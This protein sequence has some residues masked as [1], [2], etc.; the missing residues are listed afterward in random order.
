M[1]VLARYG[2]IRSSPRTIA[3]SFRSMANQ[4]QKLIRPQSE[5]VMVGQR[6]TMHLYSL[7]KVPIRK[8]DQT[9]T[10]HSLH[11]NAERCIRTNELDDPRKSD[12]NAP[13]IKTQ[14]EILG[15]SIANGNI[16][17]KSIVV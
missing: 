7:H 5:D 4:S 17:E 6:R 8:R 14:A 12:G 3:R 11:P 10:D 9:S 2:L 1:I 15:R 16:L 13:T